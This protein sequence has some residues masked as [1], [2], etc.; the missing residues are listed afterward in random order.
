MKI[1]KRKTSMTRHRYEQLLRE[2]GYT[3]VDSGLYGSVFV[4]GDHA[5]KVGNI[6]DNEPYLAYVKVAMK[7]KGNPWAP[8][9]YELTE[10]ECHAY[11]CEARDY[12]DDYFVVCMEALTEIDSRKYNKISKVSDYIDVYGN[13]YVSGEAN[14]ILV[15]EVQKIE[16]KTKQPGLLTICNAIVRTRKKIGACGD[17]HE[18]N[19]MIRAETGEYVITDPIC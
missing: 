1:I 18:G 2:E 19:V 7:S 15:S 12:R 13:E 8:R 16:K 5:V 9:I 6:W 10:Y 14:G 3:Y 4:K 11:S 17:L